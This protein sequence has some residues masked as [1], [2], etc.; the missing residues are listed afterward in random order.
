MAGWT[1]AANV[2]YTATI[3]GPDN[4]LPDQ[5]D[6]TAFEALKPRLA[7]LWADVFPADDQPYTSVVV[8]SMSV[9]ADDLARAQHL[10]FYEE[11]L[12]FLLIRLRNPHARVVYLTSQPIPGPIIDYYLHFLA[13]IPASHAAARLTLLSTY[14][15]S[16]RPL[17]LKILE[18]PRLIQRIRAAI[19]DRS[20]AYLT[21][22]RATPLERRLAVALDV[23]LNAADPKM[24][25]LCRKSG[26]R[27]ILREAG[28][29]VAHGYEDLR[30]EDDLVDALQALQRDRPALQR[31]IVKVDSSYWDEGT[32]LLRLPEEF[33]A[34][35]EALRRSLTEL[36]TPTGEPSATF[37]GRFS[38]L[39]GVVEECIEAR[40]RADASVQLRINPRGKVF[41]TSTHDEVQT[42]PFRLMSRGSLF[43][44]DEAYRIRLQD[45]GLRVGEVLAARGLV[46]RVSIEFLLSRDDPGDEWQMIAH[47]INLGVGGATHPLLA[48]RFL[49]GG[50]LDRRTGL[51]VSPAGKPKF[52]RSTDYLE[53]PRWRGLLPDDLIEAL[54]LNHL[55]YSQHGEAGA[56]F[57]MLGAISELGRVGVVAIGNSRVEAD[58]V[59]G[60]VVQT[61][62]RMCGATEGGNE[63]GIGR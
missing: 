58:A 62:D 29:S 48:V 21:V 36:E 56:L 23:P 8:P 50:E 26:A 43:P 45:A 46:S 49:T 40:H 11:I 63:G 35:R 47:D 51:F 9:D 24:D 7:Q 5:E 17:T 53:S 34:P 38:R 1:M 27:Q 55:N 41:L 57:Y 37:L 2:Q 59:F 10:R 22:L 31:A 44:A 16:P 54:T 3:G 52:Y 4:V 13:G 25:A 61:L 28:L 20:R 12:L 18:R 30:D 60:R 32:A 19:P 33:P 6:E 42:G 14:D 15:G 39:G